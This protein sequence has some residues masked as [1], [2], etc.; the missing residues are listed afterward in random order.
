M[1]FRHGQRQ[2]ALGVVGGGGEGGVVVPQSVG[3][4]DA[5]EA[6]SAVA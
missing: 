1:T 5:S 2:A 6:A 3:S 4:P